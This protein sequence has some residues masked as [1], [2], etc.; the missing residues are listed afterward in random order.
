M[1]AF[2]IF[3]DVH[4]NV[5]AL[6]QTWRRLTELGLTD[7]TVLN[8]GDTVAYGDDSSDC[9]DFVVD[10][11]QIV[12]VGGNYDYNVADFP[13]HQ[14][15]FARKWKSGRPEKYLALTEASDRINPSQREWN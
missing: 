3:S 4:G 9:I 2:G 13:E 5:E 15:R 12:T 8:A 11:H 1:S 14:T 6:K 7:R 10:H